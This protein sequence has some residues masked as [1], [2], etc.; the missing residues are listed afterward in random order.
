MRY[1]VRRKQDYKKKRILFILAA[2]VFVGVISFFGIQIANYTKRNRELS[3][4]Q[5]S[6][7]EKLEAEQDRKQSL[8]DEEAYIK[9]KKYIEERAKEIGYVYP[10]EIIFRKD[11]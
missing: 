8:N 7:Q 6:L 1:A 11:E 9:T 3:I 5:D 4:R 2:V 10:D